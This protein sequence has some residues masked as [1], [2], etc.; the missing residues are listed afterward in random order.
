[1]ITNVIV[2]AISGIVL[3]WCVWSF[4]IWAKNGFPNRFEP[5]EE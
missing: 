1:M 4:S 3:G 5:P 2:F